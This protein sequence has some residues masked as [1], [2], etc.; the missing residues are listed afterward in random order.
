MQITKEILIEYFKRYLEFPLFFLT[1]KFNDLLFLLDIPQI[2]FRK[3]VLIYIF[4]VV[5][6]L[7]LCVI[8]VLSA[9]EKGV[10]LRILNEQ[11][12]AIQIDNDIK[13]EQLKLLQKQNNKHK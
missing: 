5:Y 4:S 3:D 9:E 13:K 10:K 1:L 11:R 6:L 2:N 12:R 8:R 7:A